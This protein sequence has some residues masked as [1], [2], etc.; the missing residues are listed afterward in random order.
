MCPCVPKL[1]AYSAPSLP[2][3]HAP[4]WP[5]LQTL[6]PGQNPCPQKQ[7]TKGQW[8]SWGACPGASG[9]QRPRACHHF[10]R[11]RQIEKMRPPQNPRTAVTVG[12]GPAVLGREAAIQN[13]WRF[14]GKQT[15]HPAECVMTHSTRSVQSSPPGVQP[16]RKGCRHFKLFFGL[17]SSTSKRQN[18]KIQCKLKSDI[19]T[20]L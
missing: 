11:S 13:L 6:P 1:R 2:S 16:T 5:L 18:T 15:E 20:I 10:Q 3:R 19:I 12:S 7:V 14:T 9:G 4:G 17:N 8:E